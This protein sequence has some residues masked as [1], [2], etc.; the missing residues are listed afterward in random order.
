MDLHQSLLSTELS[1]RFAAI[2]IGTNSMRLIIAEAL[3]D[4]NY[5]ILDE[6]KE[7]TRLGA[8]L[9]STGKLDPDAVRHSIEA[10]RRM[11]Q[12]ADGYQV[13]E[14]RVIATCAVREATDGAA[15][16]RQVKREVGLKVECITAQ[17]E[18]HLAFASVARAFDL[19]GKEVAV[20]DIGGGSTEIVL[21][22]GGLIEAIYTTPLGAV[23]IGEMFGNP[24]GTWGDNYQAMLRGIDKLL[25][26][27]TD[28]PVFQPH[29][30][31]GSGGTFTTLAEMIMGQKKQP[32]LPVRGYEINLAEVT[33]LL[34]RV[35]KMPLK[36][37]RNVPGLSPDRLDIIVPG[38]AVIDRVMRRLKVN[39]LQ[40]HDRGV[41]DG[42][43]LSMLDAAVG[44]PEVNPHDREAAVDRFAT[45]CGT[46]LEHGRQVARLSGEI[47]T[48]LVEPF[49]LDPEDRPLL[50]AAARLQDAG[51][52]INYEKHHKHSYHLIINSRLAGFQPH[53]LQLVAN[54]ARY[55]RGSLPKKKHTGYAQLSPTDQDRVR[56]MAAILR[57]AGGLDRSHSQ[58]V[59][60]VEV[61]CAEGETTM[62][63]LADLLPD[64]DLWGAQSRAELF[65]LAFDTRLTMEWRR[66]GHASFVPPT[67]APVASNGTSTS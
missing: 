33:H 7:S 53:E 32:G 13:R 51:Y 34:E 29:L 50:E 54:V 18:A 62:T 22:S 11:K 57:I 48:Q 58:Q 14:M 41:R 47:Y 3:R 60:S 21:A 45:A 16:R 55:H 15:F 8:R 9:S 64:A 59:R 17:K 39:R 6:E 65:E 43:L 20:A 27:H 35:R 4:G 67:V 30:L 28:K 26:K 40:V 49:A 63:V 12:I 52:L 61:N 5:R 38:L 1:H 66:P 24:G 42:L 23:R 10:L 37:R 46:D 25:K 19:K 56:K 2:D 31:I 44:R 36:T